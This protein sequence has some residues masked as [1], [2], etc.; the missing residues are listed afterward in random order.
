MVSL[1][2]F[3]PGQPAYEPLAAFGIQFATLAMPA[4]LILGAAAVAWRYPIGRRRHRVIV[5]AL[6]RRQ[7]RNETTAKGHH[8]A[9]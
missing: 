9:V 8:E 3:K 7:S 6:E 5:R 2:G 1:F 4:L